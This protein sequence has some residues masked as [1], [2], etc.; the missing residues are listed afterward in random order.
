[1]ITESL[2]NAWILARSKEEQALNTRYSGNAAAL[3]D[4]TESGLTPLALAP[5]RRP[6]P[7]TPGLLNPVRV[8][9]TPV[10]L[11]FFFDVPGL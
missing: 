3:T 6:F 4:P 5:N 2:A 7:L 1:M 9:K 11:S 8:S 10:T